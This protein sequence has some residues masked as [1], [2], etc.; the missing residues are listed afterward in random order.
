MV[1]AATCSSGV[2]RRAAG[3]EERDAGASRAALMAPA[4]AAMNERA[5][6]AFRVDFET[7][8]GDFAV[9]VHRQWAPRGTDRFYNL[10]RHGFYDG[11]RFFRVRAGYIAQFGL[12]GDPAITAVWKGRA[13][14]DDPV[15]ES[16]R[17]GTLAYAMT[18]PDTRTTQIFINLAENTHLDAE[19]FAPFARVVRGMD[20]V[21]RLYAGYGEAAGGGM[22]G[23][24]QGRIEAGGNEYLQREFPELDHIERAVLHAK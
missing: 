19:G 11:Q 20:V 2:H 22:R 3:G 12:P 8:E 15:K 24:K 18:G 10:V 16:N 7:S 17:R 4:S 23:G 9:E 5:P 21:D 13:M 1:V 14:P 6:D